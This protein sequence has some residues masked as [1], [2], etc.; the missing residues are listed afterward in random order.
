MRILIHDYAGYPFPLDLSRELAQRGHQVW[1][2]HFQDIQQIKAGCMSE[3]KNEGSLT[4]LGLTLGETFDKHSLFKRRS[5]DLRYARLAASQIAAFRPEVVLSGNTPLEVQKCLRVA[6]HKA[7]AQFYFWVQDFYS[8]AVREFLP[9]RLPVAGHLV[10]YYYT[11]L[12][13]KL[14][15]G[16]AG[17]VL[18]TPDFLDT[19]IAWGID[20]TRCHVIENWAPVARNAPPPAPE[21]WKAAHGFTGKRLLLYSGTLGKKHNPSLLVELARAVLDQPDIIVAVVSTGPGAE[22]LKSAAAVGNLENLRVL[23]FQPIEKLPDM[24]AAAEVLLGLL[25][26]AAGAFSVPSK[27]LTYLAAGKPTLLSMPTEN[28][29]TR[30]ISRIGAGL[31]SPPDR[32]EEWVN[33]ALTLL[34]DSDLRERC[35]LAAT[36]YAQEAFNI[37]RIT[38]QFEYVFSG[39]GSSTNS[40][41]TD[42]ALPWLRPRPL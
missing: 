18:I 12:E 41:L 42:G 7:G 19:A 15:R 38:T 27:V 3:S 6:A 24:L 39:K 13:R 37:G 21:E 32:P 5:Q 23:P 35:S 26:Q 33:A 40:G 22:W 2:V 20:P 4:I 16:S 29:A 28:L 11:H 10:G 17:I 34:R 31:V 9:K 14:L 8:L 36:R 25:D 30:T 1:H